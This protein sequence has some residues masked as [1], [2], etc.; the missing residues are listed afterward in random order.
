MEILEYLR[1]ARRR[2]WVLVLV[3]VVAAALAAAFILLQPSTFTA[4]ATVNSGALVGNDGSPFSGTQ[5][6]QSFVSAF[7]AASS[8][9][10]VK[11]KVATATG[12]SPSDQTDGVTVTPVGSSSDVQV[13]YSGLTAKKTSAVV[14]ETARQSLDLIFSSR[15]AAATATRDRAVQA[16]QEANAA[17]AALAVKYKIADPPRAYQAALS[18]V[19]SL[20]QQQAQ[21]R[22]SGNAAGAAAMDAP[23]AS[24]QSSL[25]RYIPILA[26]YNN[27]AATQAATQQDLA[28]TQAQ[29]RMGVS[30][31][32]AAQGDSI[33]YVGQA[34][35]TSRLSALV[36]TVIPVFGAGIF[37]GILL[38][39]LL[40]V[41]SRL[42]QAARA[43]RTERE[44]V[45]SSPDDVGT[46]VSRRPRGT[47]TTG[48]EQA[49]TTDP[50]VAEPASRSS[51]R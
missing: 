20:Q 50:P 43:E 6:A 44:A 33:I 12:V 48:D 34:L 9:P 35:P 51:S 25:A 45:D 8:N 15:A 30:L 11:A 29:Y 38:V 31:Q 49:W 4:T 47:D 2:W 3:P 28:A 17:I 36:T 13:V 5:A 18:Q 21:L 7:Q 26:E 22:A 24:A 46:R 10:S 41:I 23:I 39:V 42:R 16:A 40:E 32:S 27:L 37:L 14:S 1:V 19:G